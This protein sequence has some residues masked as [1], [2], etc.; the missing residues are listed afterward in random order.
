MKIILELE[1]VEEDTNISSETI[2]EISKAA[3]RNIGINIDS[4]S[5]LWKLVYC[6]VKH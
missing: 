4:E 5:C 1:S 2:F 3:I 6:E